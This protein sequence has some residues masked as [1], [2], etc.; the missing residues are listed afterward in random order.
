MKSKQII[1][2]YISSGDFDSAISSL[3][4]NIEM[5]PQ[6]ALW[7]Y[8]RGKV[9]WRMG[10]KADAISDYEESAHLDPDSPAVHALEMTQD[11]MDFFNH[12]MMNP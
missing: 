11:V 10:R 5:E 7:W 8:Q 3:D 9:Y 2:D 1:E 12:D 6:N 4:R